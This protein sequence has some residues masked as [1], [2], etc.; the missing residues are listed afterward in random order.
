M[1]LITDVRRLASSRA[2]PINRASTFIDLAPSGAPASAAR[3]VLHL[4]AAILAARIGDTELA[5]SHPSAA[6][7]QIRPG[8]ERANYY[9]TKFGA[10]NVG[11]HRVAVPVELSDGTTAVTR[12]A[13]IRL[14]RGTAP[15]RS[16]H[17]WIDLSRAWLLHGDHRHALDSLHE[18]R[19][20]APQLTRYH[21][22]V[23]ETVYALLD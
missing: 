8:Q 3:G 19:R 6:V 1:V 13:T 20:I 15:S 5:D 4:R 18:A 10:A 21:P 7:E 11:I 14:P 17:Y 12:T 2:A 23:R 16:G 22:Q 9:G